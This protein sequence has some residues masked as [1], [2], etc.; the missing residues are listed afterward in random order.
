MH[1][2][3]KE[4]DWTLWRSEKLLQ[5]CKSFVCVCVWGGGVVGEGG[6]LFLTLSYYQNSSGEEGNH[7]KPRL[8]WSLSLSRS[9]PG[10]GYYPLATS[11]GSDTGDWIYKETDVDSVFPKLTDRST[12]F[13]VHIISKK[14][15]IFKLFKDGF[16]VNV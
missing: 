8:V 12:T 11:L 4:P 5:S 14:W 16:Y 2:C 15:I 13:L 10:I 6:W 1:N 9:R 7:K 3:T